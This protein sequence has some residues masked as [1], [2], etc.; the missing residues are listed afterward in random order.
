MQVS[1]IPSTLRFDISRS[2]HLSPPL[3]FR[4]KP[5]IG[6][7]PLAYRLLTSAVKSAR[8][9]QPFP[10]PVDIKNIREIVGATRAKLKTN[11]P[12]PF[13]SQIVETKT[14]KLLARKLNAVI[15]DSDPT[16]H[17]EVRVIR[18][19]CKKIGSPRLA[20]YTLYTTCEPCPMCL[21]ACIWAGLDRVV[22]GTVVRPPNS[23][24]PPLFEYSAKEFAA[25]CQLPCVVEGPVEE[26]LCRALVD[27]P[28]IQKYFA[29]LAKKHIHI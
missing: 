24:R 3:D 8:G 19:A 6:S 26:S 28:V 25:K 16:G 5:P 22:Y 17:A 9:A 23:T 20:G 11:H 18:Y 10:S 29:K 13:G 4:G 14:S 1:V 2:P 21:T 15:P 7:S 27:D 12:S